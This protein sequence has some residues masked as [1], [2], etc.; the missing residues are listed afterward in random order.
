MNQDARRRQ[1]HILSA[2]FVIHTS[3]EMMRHKYTEASFDAVT[4]KGSTSHEPSAPNRRANPCD[5]DVY[6]HIPADILNAVIL[7]NMV[8]R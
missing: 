3:M 1:T 4:A 7:S 2:I 8:K 6:F 5:V